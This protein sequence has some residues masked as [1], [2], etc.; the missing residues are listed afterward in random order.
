[1]NK[2]FSA[3][4]VVLNTINDSYHRKDMFK[5]LAIEMIT[6]STRERGDNTL[7]TEMIEAS[8]DIELLRWFMDL[9]ITQENKDLAESKI[10]S[11][12]FA[13]IIDSNLF[14]VIIL[15][16]IFAIVM[17]ILKKRKTHIAS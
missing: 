6:G 13:S 17:I 7:V 12:Q 15:G 14:W 3:A 11:V 5:L 10:I 16:G 1:M 9:K 2:D 4:L 8:N